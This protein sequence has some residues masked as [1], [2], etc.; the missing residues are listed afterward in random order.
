MNILVTGGAGFIGSCLCRKLLTEGYNVISYDL[1]PCSICPSFVADINN[2]NQLNKAVNQCDYV[3]HLAA[4]AN[5]DQARVQQ[6]KTLKTNV[7]GTYN[8]AKC[9]EEASVPLTYASTVCVYGNTPDRPS[10]EDSVC[11]PTDFY[12]A[13]KLIGE[14]LI[15][16]VMHSSEYNILR[17]GTTYGP[18]MRKA[19]AIHRFI[20][21]TFKDEP[22]T[23]HGSGMQTRCMIYIDDLVNACYRVL[24]QG[25]NNETLNLATDEELS[26]LQVAEMIINLSGKPKHMIFVPDRPGQIMREQ[27]SINKACQILN[28]TP[29]TKMKEG[30]KKTW[31]WMGK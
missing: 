20:T 16:E 10:S 12:G 30:L 25:I 26:A 11:L 23:I 5:T 29:K 22:L 4:V 18:F 31:E 13:T 7:Q 24:Q 19:L 17:F 15:Q 28:W 1:K 21:Q 6:D 14:N 9:C 27:I 3:F 2:L 8:I